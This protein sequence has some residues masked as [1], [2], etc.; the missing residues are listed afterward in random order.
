M[1]YLHELK[2]KLCEELQEIAEKQDMSAGDL[3]AVHKLTDT[4]KNIDKIEMLEADGYS[5]HGGDWEARGNY[6][7]MYRDDR[8]SRRGRDMRGRYSRH[9]G[10]DKRLMDELEELMRTIEPGK[11]DVIRRALEELKEA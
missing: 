9:D 2:E 4:I 10:T 6:D 3:E 1:K 11:R 7:G 8:Y 5:N